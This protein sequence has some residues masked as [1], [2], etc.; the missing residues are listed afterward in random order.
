MGKDHHKHFE[1]G[2]SLPFL[3]VFSSETKGNSNQSIVKIVW[4]DGRLSSQ[5]NLRHL[6][7]FDKAAPSTDFFSIHIIY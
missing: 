6:Y 4:Q 7:Q 3:I 5:F 1:L 2:P